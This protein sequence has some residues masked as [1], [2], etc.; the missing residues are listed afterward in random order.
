MKHFLFFQSGWNIIDNIQKGTPL[1]SLNA[2]YVLSCLFGFWAWTIREWSSQSFVYNRFFFFIQK[3]TPSTGWLYF[4]NVNP[5][6]CMPCTINHTQ[7]VWINLGL[8]GLGLSKEHQLHHF[9][10]YKSWTQFDLVLF[11]AKTLH[12]FRLKMGLINLDTNNPRT[13][14]I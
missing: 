11:V 12:K 8:G 10:L 3:G 2:H 4:G 7:Q 1:R 6:V 13:V 5:M 14:P 9:G